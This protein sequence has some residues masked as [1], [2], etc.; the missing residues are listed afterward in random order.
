[1]GDVSGW[2]LVYHL[3]PGAKATRAVSRYQIFLTAPIVIVVVATLVQARLRPPLLVVALCALLLAENANTLPPLGV[4]RFKE[5]ARLEAIGR[6]PT[7]C[8][9]FVATAARPG[10]LYG[11]DVDGKY[12]HNVDAMMVA[13]AVQL[14]TINGVASFSPPWWDLFYPG[15]ADYRQRLDAYIARFNLERPCELDLQNS[16]WRRSSEKAS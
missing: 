11:P 12:S 8:T 13:E 7:E 2:W 16:Q 15:A 10:Q 4:A 3:V 14:P 5:V 9:Y 1:M 6:P